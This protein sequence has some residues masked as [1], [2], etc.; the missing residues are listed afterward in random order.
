MSAA[1]A[2]TLVFSQEIEKHCKDKVDQNHKKNGHDDGSSGGAADLLRA[3]GCVQ[4]FEATDG[5]DGGAEHKTFNEASEDIA[6]KK[7]VER[8]DDVAGKSEVRLGNAE[9]RASQDAHEVCPDGE[10]GQHQEHGDEFRRDQKAD[11]IDGHGFQGVN[12][13]G[14]LHSS[15]FGGKRRAGAPNDDDRGDERPQLARHGEGDGAGDETDSAKPLQFVRRLQRQNQPDKKRDQRK[16]GERANAGFHSLGDSALKSQWLALEW[17]DEGE[18][19]SATRQHRQRA[20]VGQTAFDRTTYFPKEFHVFRLPL[21]GR[22]LARA[23]GSKRLGFTIV[24]LENFLQARELHDFADGLAETVKDKAGAL[25]ARGFETFDEGGDAGAVNVTD[26]FQ[27]EKHLGSFLLLDF[28]KQ[29]FAH[30]RRMSQ[31]NVPRDIEDGATCCESG[32]YLHFCSPSDAAAW[33]VGD[34]YFTM[35]KRFLPFL[36]LNSTS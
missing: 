3:A 7:G 8:G 21:R 34:K 17:A 16:D 29:R 10:A 22:D 25:V 35:R 23:L 5:S 32:R 2:M 28:L 30:G 11:R 26:L 15:E 20:D 36:R 13:L 18:I 9:E 1:A 4:T 27:I 19:R 14:N 31:I 33:E 24:N 12:F 6:H